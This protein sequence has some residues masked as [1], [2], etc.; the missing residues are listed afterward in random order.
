MPYGIQIKRLRYIFPLVVISLSLTG[1]LIHRIGEK[2]LDE[3]IILK[4]MH[5]D[6]EFVEINDSPPYYA[7]ENGIIVFNSYNVVPHIR[8]YSGPIKL[9]ISMDN[10]GKI[11]R[12]KIIEHRETENFVHYMLK[13]EY[14]SQ[15]NGKDISEPFEVDR[16]IDGISRATVSV[17]ALAETV[18]ESSRL[19][20]EKVFG[21]KIGDS[22]KRRHI[23]MEWI[24]YGSLFI[25]AFISYRL[26]MRYRPFLSSRDIFLLLSLLI[27]GIYLGSPVSIIHL[28][29]LFLGN[30]SSSFLW[31]MVIITMIIS[32]LI[33]GRFY[34]GWLCPMAAIFDLSQRIPL[35]KRW[36]VPPELD[37]RYRFIKYIILFMVSGVILIGRRVDYGNIEPYVTIFSLHGNIFAW[38]LVFTVVII[39]FRVKR[40]WCRFL[41]PLG[42]ITALYSM[43]DKKYVSMPECP[44]ENPQSPL[45]SECIRCNSCLRRNG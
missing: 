39:N 31:W 22:G 43:E 26:S 20:G 12:L 42:G 3:R 17:R 8:G 13:D 15:F 21:I 14:L 6:I 11:M 40:F 33:A 44:M 9:L 10:N 37:Y 7:S 1:Y 2:P 18:K 35:K 28:M 38:I 36:N 41:C 16:D 30:T 4:V 27:T 32:I 19:M 29:A 25:T 24:I 34:C 45:T 5:P 23:E